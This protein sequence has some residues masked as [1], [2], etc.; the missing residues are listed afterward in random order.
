M[1]TWPLSSLLANDEAD[2]II[3]FPQ[4]APL[5]NLNDRD[6]W[7]ARARQ[8]AV[9]RRAAWVA[10]YTHRQQVGPQH[11]PLINQ[12]VTVELPVKDRRRRDPHNFTPSAK[13]LVDGL[14]DA[15]IFADDSHEHLSVAEPVLHIIGRTDEPLVRI[16]VEPR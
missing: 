11:F 5:L 1:A 4:P 12:V 8:V 10:G 3:T 7:R 2:V 6:H 14:V 9:W 13:A 15:G 16:R